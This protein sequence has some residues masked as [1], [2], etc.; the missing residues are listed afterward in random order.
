VVSSRS[1]A[2]PWLRQG[3][4]AY[5]WAVLTG[6]VVGRAAE[7]G[8]VEEFLESLEAGPSVLLLEG[9]PGIGKTTLWQG[10]VRRA[11]ELDVLVLTSRPG[12]SETRLT[13]S[14]LGDL[15]VDVH[16][17][18]LDELPGPQRRALDV[19]LLRAEPEG[20]GAEQRV[21][22]TAFLG[23][24]RVLAA[25]RAV[26]VA[27]DDLQWLDASS[28]RVL[29]FAVRRLERE[30]L[31]ILGATRPDGAPWRVFGDRSVQRVRLGPLS[32][33]ALFEILKA[34][35]GRTF[36]RPSL[37]RIAAASNGN[38][39]FAVEL[40]RA[41]GEHDA[42]AHASAPLP[43][44]NDLTDLLAGRLA[45]LPSRARHALLVASALSAPTLDLLDRAGIARAEKARVVTVGDDGSLRFSHPLLAAAVYA[46]ASVAERRA[47]HR[48]LAARV[49]SP[50]ERARHLALAAKAPDER[51]AEVLADA[52]RSARDRGAPD[53]AIELLELACDR[54]PAVAGEQLFTRKLDLGRFLSE[55]GDP[56]RA[57]AVLRDVAGNAPAGVVRAR[58]LLLLAFMS[59]TAEAGETA[60]ELCEHALEAA[61]DDVHLRIEILAA[62]SR[63]SDHDVARK[64]SYARRAL[65]L[66]EET[67]ASAQLWSYALLASA[68]AEFFAGRGLDRE[69]LR[70]AEE[71]ESAAARD[72]SRV[73]GRSLHRVHHYSDVRPSARLRGILCIYADELDEARAE[74]RLEEA[75]AREH[76]DE[77]Q[78]TRTLIRLALIELRAGNWHLARRHLEEAATLAD[79]TGQ[80]ALRRWMLAT[81]TV[82]D[83]S[84]GRVQEA[85]AT[86]EEAL[87][88]SL[89]AGTVWGVAECH[90]ALG[91]LELSG[92]DM[93]A[94]SAQ[95]GS[96]AELAEHIGPEEPRL[97][98]S[99][100][101]HVEAL[102]ALGELDAAEGVLT[103]LD[104]ASSA[105]AAATGGR[106][107]AL[108]SSARGDLNG[109]AAAAGD[110]L[111][112][113]ERLPLPFELARTLLAKGQIL[114]RRKERR[115]ASEAL[116]ESVGLFEKLGAPGWAERARDERARLG[117]QKGTSG[118]LTPS[119]HTVAS[120]AASGLTN[121]QIAE[122]IFVSPKTVEAN[123]ARAYRKLG[124]HSRAELGAYVAT[125]ERAEM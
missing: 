26:L 20:E 35:L 92:G 57:A 69:T 36:A 22:S 116:D 81:Q 90:A 118:E 98:R 80:N 2:R 61:A 73:A 21:V 31:G 117:L 76:G 102:V 59:E 24:L 16:D 105:W 75:V 51:V 34:E 12:A 33:A 62:G 100:A 86:G 72:E 38:P 70:R 44:P 94:A 67:D 56:Q 119:E 4:A 78:L 104:P 49:T 39:F 88:L 107:R 68:E 83:A 27:I 8:V 55:A 125:L 46:N 5:S 122:R 79:R 17:G 50:E 71:L 60:N 32:L 91:F 108:L 48:K 106:C 101:D 7:L 93:A 18:V 3:D 87:A 97:L 114:R 124:I 84:C 65:A 54:T 103:R 53:A 25:E 6:A 29:E 63:M 109:A 37:V 9:E 28:R 99:Q 45:R 13:F 85:R 15:L 89:E 110:A 111:V 11:R 115:L 95:L 77:V 41:L 10:A 40:A 43:V 96:A 121:R 14:A 42:P 120:L 112:A 1:R 58:A 30:R 66:A 113:H 52:A 23:V 82:L 74:F 19:A 64:I 123:L 47:V